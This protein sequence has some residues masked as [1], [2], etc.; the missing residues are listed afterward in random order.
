MSGAAVLVET[1]DGVGTVTLNRPEARN[2]LNPAL[3][4]ELE[5]A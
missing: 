5:E 3:L 4:G 1:R 2:A